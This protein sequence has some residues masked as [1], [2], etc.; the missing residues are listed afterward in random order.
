MARKYKSLLAESS[1]STPQ[2]T[3]CGKI[4]RPEIKVVW[5]HFI[6]L[7]DC[8]NCQRTKFFKEIMKMLDWV[9]ATAAWLR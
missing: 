3:I 5:I 1:I 4:F 6:G 9:I 7:V 8:E 2:A